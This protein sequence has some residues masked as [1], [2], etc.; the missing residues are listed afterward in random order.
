[1]SVTVRGEAAIRRELLKL[2]K[3][4][5]GAAGAALY[6]EGM[7]LWNAAVKRTPVE[8]GVLRNSAY[9]SPP[10]QRG[11]NV[12]V[13]V[14][15]GTEYAIPQHERLDYQHPRGGEAKYLSN[16]I[17]LAQPGALERLAKRTQRNVEAGVEAPAIGAAPQR[18]KGGGSSRR[19]RRRRP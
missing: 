6:Q 5:P 3:K 18:P 2:A 9:V 8:F 10:T 17:A 13:E 1:M 7:G 4:Y 19:T 11:A 16:A 12:T 15:F 14:G